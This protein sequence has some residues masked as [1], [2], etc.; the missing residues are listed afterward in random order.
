MRAEIEE[1]KKAQEEADVRKR[2]FK[3][4]LANFQSSDV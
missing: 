2:A 1:R 4:N 3:A